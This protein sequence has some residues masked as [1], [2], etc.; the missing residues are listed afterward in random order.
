[1]MRQELCKSCS[2]LI[3]RSVILF[4]FIVVQSGN[5]L[6]Q[7]LC[8]I[9]FILLQLDRPLNRFR[10]YGRVSTK[11]ENDWAIDCEVVNVRSVDKT[12]VP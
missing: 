6:A 7:F 5:I 12:K 11:E 10:C 9:Y 3:G 4:Y 1:M 8:K 2:R